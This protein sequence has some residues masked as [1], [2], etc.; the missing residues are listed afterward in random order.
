MIHI[1]LW[2]SNFVYCIIDSSCIIMDSLLS[3]SVST[4]SMLRLSLPDPDDCLTLSHLVTSFCHSNKTS[5]MTLITLVAPTFFYLTFSLCFVTTDSGDS[6]VIEELLSFRYIPQVV[7]GRD[8]LLN[9]HYK[10]PITSWWSFI[11]LTFT[12]GSFTAAWSSILSYQYSSHT[13]AARMN[14]YKVG[15]VWRLAT[16]TS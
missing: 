3:P 6:L 14:E 2:P 7:S 8:V 13:Y 15:Y 1:K 4:S 11:R 5:W 16:L 12:S 9:F 10:L